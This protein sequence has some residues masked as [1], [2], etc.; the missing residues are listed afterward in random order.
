MYPD[1]KKNV[2]ETWEAYEV[3]AIASV[4][5]KGRGMAKIEID[6]SV[7]RRHHLISKLSYFQSQ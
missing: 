5:L 1:K 6:G 2:E 4:P 3:P 7:F